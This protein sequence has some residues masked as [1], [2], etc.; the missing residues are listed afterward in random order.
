MNLDAEV[1]EYKGSP[2][3]DGKVYAEDF[4]S[5]GWINSHKRN[6]IA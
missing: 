2:N 4:I 5:T 6:I 3:A 1:R